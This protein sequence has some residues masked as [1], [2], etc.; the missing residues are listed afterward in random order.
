MIML[1]SKLKSGFILF[2][3]ANIIMIF[4]GYFMMQSLA[5]AIGNMVFMITNIRGFLK[6]TTNKTSIKE[7]AE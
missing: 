7:V 4:V 5:I 1:G 2:A 3:S 6:W